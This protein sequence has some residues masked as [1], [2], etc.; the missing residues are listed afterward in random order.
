MNVGTN[1]LWQEHYLNTAI[2]NGIGT[3]GLSV[4]DSSDN[5]TDID[6]NENGITNEIGENDPT[7]F[8]LK[9]TGLYIPDGFSPNDD[10]INDFF[11]IKGIENYPDNE[12]KVF[13]RWGNL[14]YQKKQYDN[15][16]DGVPNS[17]MLRAGKGKV[18][19]GTY[20]YVLEFNTADLAPAKGYII[21]Q[22]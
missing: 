1:S 14:I 5:G 8:T 7:P 9:P 11:V 2:G 22:Y 3:L 17:G 13:N 19:A 4:T 6:P 16:W 12:F 10:G 20:Y 21:V 15:T 18:Q